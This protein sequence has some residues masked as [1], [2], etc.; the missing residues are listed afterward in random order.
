MIYKKFMRLIH[1][2][3]HLKNE[4]IFYRLFY[5][6]RKKIRHIKKFNYALSLS[7]SS[8]SLQLHPSIS[9][10]SSYGKQTFTFLNI[11]T[12]FSKTIDWNY[13]KNGKLW[14]YNLTYFDCLHQDGI[15][16]DE[17]LM[18]IFDFIDQSST[19]KDGLEPFPISLRGINWIKFLVQH[20]INDSKIDDSLFA[21]YHILLDN[22]EYHLL[23]NHLLENGF[24][25]LFGAYYFQNEAFYSS[26]KKILTS[27]LEEQILDDGAHFELSPMYHQIMLFRVLDCINLLQNNLWKNQELLPLLQ[28]KAAIMLGWLKTI[29]YSDGTIPL[30]N[31][32]A[33]GIA[34]TSPDLINYAILLDI[35][36]LLLPLSKSGYRKVINEKY[37]CIVDVGNIGPDYILGH[38]HS[39]TFNFELHIDSRPIIVDTGLSTYENNLQRNTERSTVSHNTVIMD[40][41]EQSEVWGGF[42]VARRAK[43]I[44]LHEEV[45][46]IEATHDG[47]K[48]IN[49]FHNRKFKFDEFCIHIRDTIHSSEKHNSIAFLHLFP[50]ITPVLHDNIIDIEVCTIILTGHSNIE[51]I[52]YEYAHEFNNRVNAYCIKIYF[53]NLLETS[54]IIPKDNQEQ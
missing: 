24:S 54:I 10:Y 26:A 25:L 12:S 49:T 18:L 29:T 21:Q 27:E 45:D 43:I 33:N 34:P 37:E 35:Q 11:I 40:G 36:T 22:L 1:T 5:L 51:I 9:A 3:K 47:Y 32:S 23:G 28:S 14:T 42:R 31:D 30:L 48:S 17:G 44:H 52:T 2:I 50:N 8:V 7:S 46:S 16:I 20:K 38:A 53:S 39:D 4:Q 6:L 41:K 13:Q 15:L 19:I